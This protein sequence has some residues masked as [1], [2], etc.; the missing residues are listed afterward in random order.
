MLLRCFSGGFCISGKVFFVFSFAKSKSRSSLVLDACMHSLLY[1]WS[2][3]SE[4]E[5]CENALKLVESTPSE[6]T[7]RAGVDKEIVLISSPLFLNL[8][9]PDFIAKFKIL[10]LTSTSVSPVQFYMYAHY[11]IQFSVGE[12]IRTLVALFTGTG[13]I[14]PSVCVL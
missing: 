1:W 11:N 6:L 13:L 4:I 8:Y 9:S 3:A 2:A 5:S 12:L 7:A 14:L 10:T